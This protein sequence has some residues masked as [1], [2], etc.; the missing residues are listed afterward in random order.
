[1]KFVYVDSINE[2]HVVCESEEGEKVVINF[3]D[4]PKNIKEGNIKKEISC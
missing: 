4:L 1:M 2:E 3:C